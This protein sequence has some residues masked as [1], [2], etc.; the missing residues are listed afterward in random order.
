MGYQCLC[1]S[2][3]FFNIFVHNFIYPQKKKN[4]KM[5]LASFLLLESFL[6]GAFSAIDLFPFMYFESILIPMYLLIGFWGGE[7]RI[8]SAYKFFLYILRF[9]FNV[10][11]NNIS[12]PRIWNN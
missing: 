6:I 4:M 9:S 1:N 2:F 7:R 8:Y 12:L 3:N 11:C 10:S 5:Y